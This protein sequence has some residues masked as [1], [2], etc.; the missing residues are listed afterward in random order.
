MKKKYAAYLLILSLALLPTMRCGLIFEAVPTLLQGGYAMAVTGEAT[1]I[2][3]SGTR[4]RLTKDLRLSADNI[5]FPGSRL[6][7]GPNSRIDLAF[8]DSI[9]VRLGA[10]SS[11]TLDA[12]RILEGEHFSQI[13]MK[14]NKG[15]IFADA[16]KLAKKSSF[17]IST[18]Q[19]IVNV[20]GTEFM[21]EET[22]SS[23]SVLVKDGSVAVTDLSGS[24]PNYVKEGEGAAVDGSGKVSVKPLT[25]TE[26]ELL[27]AM[28]SD[29]AELKSA[30][31]K[32]IRELVETNQRNIALIKEAYEA[33]KQAMGQA[34]TEQK[35]R[36][37]AAL[38]EQKS[39]DAK[40]T[41]AVKSSVSS[42]IE[43]IKNASKPVKK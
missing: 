16:G 8:S 7:T 40:N 25:G 1:I 37:T 29:I 33:Q 15:K 14:L 4:I 2:T 22:G 6:L 11:V 26:K 27:K 30:D 21:V 10:N 19:S 12:S 13:K 17:V 43:K 5:V 18:L 42:D 36:N 39:S 28:S 34:V 41:E 38:Q 23:N 32:R 24:D 3:D 35:E 9:K 20:R 31:R